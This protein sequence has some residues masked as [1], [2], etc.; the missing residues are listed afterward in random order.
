MGFAG[1]VVEVE[2]EDRTLVAVEGE[3]KAGGV[4]EVEGVVAVEGEEAF[5][6]VSM[7]RRLSW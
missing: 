3:F 5:A 6:V 1:W 4:V 2:V 7:T